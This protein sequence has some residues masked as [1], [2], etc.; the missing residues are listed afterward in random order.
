MKLAD[1][2]FYLSLAG[3]VGNLFVKMT[4][5]LISV[6]TASWIGVICAILSLLA[7]LFYE[8]LNGTLP[9]PTGP[10]L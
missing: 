5:T 7:F 2:V 4:T 3:Q 1:L 6:T 8:K 9:P 10:V